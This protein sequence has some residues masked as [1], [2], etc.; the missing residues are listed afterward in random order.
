MQL[1]PRRR[2]TAPV[3]RRED[4][5][6]FRSAMDTLFDRFF[7]EL[8]A[9]PWAEGT[10]MPSMDVSETD[11]NIQVKVDLP[12][13]ESKDIDVSVSGDLLTIRGEKEEKREEGEEE[14]QYYCQERYAGEF[15]RSIRLPEEVQSEKVDAEFKNG[16]LNI[17]LPKSGEGKT[18]KIEIRGE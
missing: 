6:T 9:E 15:Q 17:T 3:T 8:P 18:K 13:M 12:G 1:I 11:G 5:P 4:V 16:V 2:W 7:R 10:W 14:G